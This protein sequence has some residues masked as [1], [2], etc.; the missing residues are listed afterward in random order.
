MLFFARGEFSPLFFKFLIFMK[1]GKMSI[2]GQTKFRTPAQTNFLSRQIVQEYNHRS[3][4][5]FVKTVLNDL[6]EQE[7][8]NN[9]RQLDESKIQEYIENLQE[10]LNDGEITNTT[11]ANY[12]T[13]LNTI[14]DYTN[15]VTNSELEHVSAK[16]H[17]LQRTFD[18]SDKS[19]SEQQHQNF[20]DFL[21]EK[22]QQTGDNR[23]ERLQASLELQKN[24]GLRARE[25]FGLRSETIQKGLE[26]G[27][28][29]L[30]K[31]DYTKNGRE[32]M[33]EVRTDEQR[34]TLQKVQ[35]ILRE[36]NL[37]SLAGEKNL[38]R[39][40]KQ[41]KSFAYN[42][43][44]NYNKETSQKFNFHGERHSW[45]QEKYSEMWKKRTGAEIQAPIKY[46]SEQLQASGWDGSGKFYDAVSEFEIKPFWEY[47]Q[48]QVPEIDFK[49][50]DNKI[51][52]EISEEL[53]HNRLD[54]TNTYLG[55]P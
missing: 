10:R 55:H 16:E 27:K 50:I 20:K 19:I 8:I 2:V 47:V 18:Y 25:S 13:A 53:G 15:F 49:K 11:T 54:I 52:Q 34:E 24:F 9:L 42:Q 36:N 29:H 43:T 23:F 31:H 12:V 33:I 35:N 1:G 4:D 51:R 39:E 17:D 5:N 32:R 6:R 41:F 21:Q 28:L 46:Y 3:E 40:V 30:T 22:F 26:T 48:E 14:I 7:I 37:K 44:V 45:A 38:S